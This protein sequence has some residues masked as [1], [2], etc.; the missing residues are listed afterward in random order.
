MWP[1]IVRPG[2]E[3]RC[4]YIE[5]AGVSEKVVNTLPRMLFNLSHPHLVGCASVGIVEGNLRP[6][7]WY[8]AL[9]VS[10]CPWICGIA[11]SDWVIWG[12]VWGV[13]E[14]P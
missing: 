3:V 1:V 11:M 6:L 8:F 7:P 2:G 14:Y 13:A 5:R 10:G 4:G 12:E 9:G